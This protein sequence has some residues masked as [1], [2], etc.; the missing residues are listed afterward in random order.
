M[1]KPRFQPSYFKLEAEGKEWNCT[2]IIPPCFHQP[3]NSML[4]A[5]ELPAL[6][7]GN[8]VPLPLTTK[9]TPS[10]QVNIPV[11]S[12]I[13]IQPSISSGPAVTIPSTPRRCT[14]SNKGIPS[15]RFTPSKK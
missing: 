15:V 6:P 13:V 8:P 5:L 10:V 3:F 2:G 1:I 4:L 11:S 12:T 14:H 9:A 7:M